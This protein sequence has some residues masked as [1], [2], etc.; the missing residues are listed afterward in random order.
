MQQ[1]AALREEYFAIFSGEK[2]TL[3]ATSIREGVATFLSELITG[4]SE[5]KNLARDYLLANEQ[6]L[7]VGFQ[8]EMLGSEM[9]D[10]LYQ[11]PVDPDQPQ[12]VGYAMGSRIA[13]A[14]YDR[15]P[16]KQKAAGEIVAVSDYENFLALSGYGDQFEE[17]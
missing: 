15:A 9:G 17:Q 5:H 4:G 11:T 16:D 1:L 2:R 6:R 7:W 13:R 14:Y 12:D 3:L 10:W 8:K